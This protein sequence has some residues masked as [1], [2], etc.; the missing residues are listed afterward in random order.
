MVAINPQKIYGRWQSGVA[1]DFQTT[2]STFVGYSEAGHRQFET[3]RPEIAELLYQLKYRL[4]KAAAAGII[5]AAAGFLRPHRGKLDV[6][7]PV[8][9]STPRAWQP[10]QVLAAG[11]GAALNL[12]VVDCIRITRPTQQLKSVEDPEKR[13]AL[14]AGLY[15]VEATHV[16]DKNVLLF[17]DLF[18]SGSTMNAVTDVLLGKGRAKTVRALTITKSRSNQ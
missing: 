8:P 17:D 7:V 13:K 15:T 6:L 5:D 2:S 14:L 3:V 16:A 9:A 11:I 4:N 12:P 1:L 10:V 18:R